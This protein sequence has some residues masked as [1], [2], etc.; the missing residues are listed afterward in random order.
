MPSAPWMRPPAKPVTTGTR[1]RTCHPGAVVCL[2]L[3]H[4]TAHISRAHRPPGTKGSLPS[5]YHRA[6]SHHPGWSLCTKCS[7][8]WPCDQLSTSSAH[9]GCHAASQPHNLGWS[10]ASA[11]G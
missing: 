4:R 6:A 9:C 10:P 7:P 11:A 3:A 2:P 1:S 5:S 8:V